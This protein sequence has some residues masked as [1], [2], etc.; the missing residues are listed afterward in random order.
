MKDRTIEKIFLYIK[1]ITALFLWEI[2]AITIN[3]EEPFKLASGN[4]SPIYINCR[5]V[6]SFSTFMQLF[7]SFS[8]VICQ[9][10]KVGMEVVAGGETAGIPFAAYVAKSFSLPM[11]Y[12]RKKTKE[13]G[14]ANL[15]EGC[16]NEKA[17]VLLVEDLITDAASKLNFVKAINAAGG[18]VT[19]ILVL[20]D[21][22][23]G[24]KDALSAEGI[25]LHSLTDMDTA[26]YVAEDTA[27]VDANTVISV[28]EY[29]LDAKKWHQARDL[30]YHD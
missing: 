27:L 7:T 26:L 22:Q 15:V 8:Q 5:K 13:H 29:L 19:D 14:L 20:F 10:N 1:E 16:L 12:V 4:Y 30:E 25:R 21:R 23:Q 9:Y 6:I 11:V 28:R 2:G 17:R 24:G 3:L 18:I